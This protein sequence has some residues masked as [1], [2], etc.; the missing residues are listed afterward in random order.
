MTAKEFYESSALPE[1]KGRGEL[2]EIYHSGIQSHMLCIVDAPETDV[3]K[4]LRMLAETDYRLLEDNSIE[5]NR[6]LVY[7]NQENSVF[8]SYIPSTAS[9]RLVCESGKRQTMRNMTEANGC[10]VPSVTQ[11]KIRL[12]MC[13]VITLS[14][15]SFMI[16]DGGVGCAEDEE[17]LYEFL[18]QRT[19]MG[20]K[21]L[22]RAWFVSHTHPD[23]TRLVEEFLT[24]YRDRVRLLEIVY[25]FPDFERVTVVKEP[26]DR[27]QKEAERVVAT[28]KD[29]FPDAIHT[30]CHT[31]E[32]IRSI[33]VN[34]TTLI[35]HEDIY[36]I[37]LMSSNHT[38]TAW[39]FDFDSGRSFMCLGDIWTE[40][41]QQMAASFS[42][43][44]LKADIMQVTHHGLLGGHIDLYKAI[45][46]NICLWPSPAERFAG[47]W[48]DPRRVALGKD[49]VQY[50][51]GEGGCDYNRWL[52][53]NTVK[54][55]QHFHA[56]ETVII[57]V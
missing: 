14:D 42:A 25:N 29:N 46:P 40:M 2:L 7:E 1:Y 19:P 55:R 17:R 35:T 50:C 4:Y 12:G 8:F 44:Y 53:D 31:G 56:G 28:V 21:P 33:G 30:V 57:P 20:E 6:F 32:V 36:P 45:D 13:Y 34:V 48:I 11:L 23:H 41:C 43:E 3:N 38:S 39:R 18:S 5:K 49:T 47:T 52:R 16:V 27:N 9:M 37:P 15:G 26:T 54:E 51:I 22:I 10:A 24:N